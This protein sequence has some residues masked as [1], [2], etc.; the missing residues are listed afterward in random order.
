MPTC[1]SSE[2]RTECLQPVC[3]VPSAFVS[4]GRLL[5]P[6][7]VFFRQ[8]NKTKRELVAGSFELSFHVAA[9]VSALDACA[10]IR[11]VLAFAHA[12][13]ALEKACAGEVD[14]E[15]DQCE[16]LHFL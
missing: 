7:S 8:Q 14:P 6:G 12:H 1:A 3:V 13:L 16:A 10:L 2:G 11:C 9:L 15:R 5:E 4:R